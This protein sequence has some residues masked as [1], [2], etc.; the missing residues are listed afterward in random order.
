M[1]QAFA[2][3]ILVEFAQYSPFGLLVLLMGVLPDETRALLAF[4][5][6]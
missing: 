2:G 3:S 5:S 6:V 4:F 1:V